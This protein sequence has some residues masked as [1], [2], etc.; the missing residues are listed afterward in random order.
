MSEYEI[1]YYAS[2]VADDA[3]QAAVVKQF[4]AKQAGTMRYASGLH[5][6]ETKTAAK[7]YWQ[8]ATAMLDAKRAADKAGKAAA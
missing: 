7:A 3:F 8:A 6:K 1:L 5:N 2:Q 4:G